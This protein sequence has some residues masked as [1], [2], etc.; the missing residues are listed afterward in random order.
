MSKLR[1]TLL[2]LVLAGRYSHYTNSNWLLVKNSNSQYYFWPHIEGLLPGS[3]IPFFLQSKT[4]S[5]TNFLLYKKKP[6]YITFINFRYTK[7]AGTATTNIIRS[8]EKN[9][10]KC[11]LR[12]G[13]TKVL[14]LNSTFILG[15][16]TNKFNKLDSRMK[17]SYL[18]KKTK[19]VVRG[20]AMNPVDHPHG[21]RTKTNQPEVSKWGWIA[22]HSR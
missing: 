14:K 19:S 4:G 3:F 8:N 7:A 10:I 20:V 11:K 22:K 12:S 21:G 2:N 5:Y 18:Y 1:P 13:V 17:A 15:K 9:I 16:R 6:K